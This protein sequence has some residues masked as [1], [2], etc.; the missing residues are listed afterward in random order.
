M[1]CQ[2]MMYSHLGR[3]LGR[4]QSVYQQVEWQHFPV[5]SGQRAAQEVFAS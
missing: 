1:G 5:L 4:L 3:L 2:R